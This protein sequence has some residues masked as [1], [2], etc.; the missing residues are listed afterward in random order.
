VPTPGTVQ[1]IA[2]RFTTRNQAYLGQVG[3]QLEWSRGPF[4]VDLLG[5]VGLGPNHERVRNLGSTTTMVPGG[6]TTFAQGGVLAV[7]GT[8]L[9]PGGNFGTHTTN[10]FV[11]VPEVGVTGGVDVGS[12]LRLSAGYSFLYINSV[13]RPGTQVN[14]LVNPVLVPSSNVGISPSGPGQPNVITKQDD[15]WVHGLRFMLEF[16]F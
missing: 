16:R 1:E 11:I 4:F 14:R 2:D 6:P 8:P 13:A 15:F 7:P 9:V 3:A 10:W 5:K 12:H